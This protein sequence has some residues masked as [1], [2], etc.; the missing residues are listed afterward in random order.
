MGGRNMTLNKLFEK[1][2][3]SNWV[4]YVGISLVII[5]AVSS[6]SGNMAVYFIVG[7]GAFLSGQK[8]HDK[9][10]ELDKRAVLLFSSFWL[11]LIVGK[12]F[13]GMPL[14]NIVFSGVLAVLVLWNLVNLFRT[15]H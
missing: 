3:F 13:M 10:H 5:A 9:F 7:L 8:R 1:P 4:V 14:V 12:L 15:G 11:L 2:L 6:N